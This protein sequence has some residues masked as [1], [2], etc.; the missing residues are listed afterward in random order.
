MSFL[1]LKNIS[2][3]YPLG[4]SRIQALCDINVTIQKGELVSLAG[5]SGS[6]KT[7]LLNIIGCIDKPSQGT[8]QFAGEDTGDLNES[9]LTQTRRRKIGFIFQ[10]FNLIPVLTAFE[11]VEYALLHSRLNKRDRHKK[12]AYYLNAVGLLKQQRQRPN[13]LSGG[14]RQRVAIAR[15]L[16]K[17][18]ELVLADEPTANLDSRTGMS[19]IMLLKKLNKDLQTTVVFSS[20]DPEVIRHSGRVIVIQDGRVKKC[21]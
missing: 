19:I 16:V 13:E 1:T 5:S 3:E 12:V 8:Y 7:T 20:H 11:N 9:D 6:G 10:M 4:K 18:P 17:D 2:K 14:Q 21:G 15:A